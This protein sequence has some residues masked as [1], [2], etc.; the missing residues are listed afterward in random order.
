M[1]GARHEPPPTYHAPR[2]DVGPAA[3]KQPSGDPRPWPEPL[4]SPQPSDPRPGKH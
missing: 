4:K 1:A 3:Y 2:P